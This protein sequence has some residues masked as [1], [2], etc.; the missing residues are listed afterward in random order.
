MVP[1]PSIAQK[2]KNSYSWLL[3]VCIAK[4]NTVY[5]NISEYSVPPWLSWQQENVGLSSPIYVL[6][7]R[8]K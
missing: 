4:D 1:P 3:T 5:G 2:K 6:N 7:Q 8:E